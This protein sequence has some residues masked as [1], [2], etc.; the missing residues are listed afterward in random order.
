MCVCVH[1]YEVGVLVCR[2]VRLYVGV[3][4]IKQSQMICS[5]KTAACGCGGGTIERLVLILSPVLPL[6]SMCVDHISMEYRSCKTN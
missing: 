4:L 2:C 6:M 5:Q 1:L 3:L